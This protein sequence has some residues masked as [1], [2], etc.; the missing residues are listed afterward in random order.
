MELVIVVV[1]IGIVAAITIPRMSRGASE[2]GAAALIS[3]L[4]VMRSALL[5]YAAEHNG[6]YPTD[7]TTFSSQF[8]Q[9][10]D[11]L[12]GVNA[13][14]SAT[15]LYGPYLS[16]IPPLPVGKNKGKSAVVAGKN[17]GNKKSGGWWYDK[18]TGELRA[19]CKDTEVDDAGIPY[20]TY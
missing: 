13:T 19:N 20:N 16:K 3:D 4:S 8:T 2:A 18:K 15:H 9:Y 10:T 5:H 12:G 11:E 17:P 14:K 6:N 7:N 1:I